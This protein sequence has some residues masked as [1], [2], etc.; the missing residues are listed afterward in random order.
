M[1]KVSIVTPAYNAQDTIREVYESIKSQTFSDWEWL[2][3]DDCS[4]DKT[5]SILAD[6]AAKDHRVR[7]F[8]NPKNSKTAHSRNVATKNATGEYIAFLDSDD[9]WEP[10]KLEHQLAFMKKNDYSFTYTNYIVKHMNGKSKHL[11]PKHN[12]SDYKKMLKMCDVCCSTVMYDVKKVGKIYMPESFSKCEDYAAWLEKMKEGLVAH[13]LNESLT[14][15]SYG[16]PIAISHNKF[17]LIKH[18]Y[19]VYHE[20]LKFGF[21]KS[22]YYNLTYAFRRLFKGY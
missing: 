19:R 4:T 13:R 3:V 22:H 15:Y 12:Y 20:H 2:V 11:T 18:H 6:I 10:K 21:F 17:H 16:N 1:V 14:I 5:F 8:Q 9:K 7:I